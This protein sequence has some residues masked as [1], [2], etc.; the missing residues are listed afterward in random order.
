MEYI[1]QLLFPQITQIDANK[2]WFSAKIRG[3]NI[4]SF[5]T[6]TKTKLKKII[7]KRF[8]DK[9][10][11]VTGASRGLGFAIAN[12]FAKE[13]ATLAIC[14]RKEET[15]QQAADKISAVGGRVLH[16]VCDVSSTEQVNE[17]VDFVIKETGKVDILINNA[18]YVPTEM[19][20]AEQWEVDDFLNLVDTNTLSVFRFMKAVFPYMKENGGKI[21][22]MSSMAGLRGMKASVSYGT[23]KAGI[24]G[25]TQTV[26]NDW[27]KYGINVNCI[28][29]V[30]QT[31]IWAN[32]LPENYDNPFT[33]FGMRS[34]AL[35]Y[36][37]DPERHIA[38]VVGFLSS[39]DAD[40]LTGVIIPVDGGLIDLE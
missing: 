17:F 29:P 36:A 23:S 35:E 25:L 37:G 40:Y 18:A 4:H 10:V 7:M 15:L 34:N 33:A 19:V 22:N 12:Y 13:G 6:D 26:A 2:K 27:G 38:P 1:N 24:V 8:E 21:V 20:S 9:V 28:A 31:E 3:I 39:T 11:I 30:A 16:K 5:T 14:S 32:V